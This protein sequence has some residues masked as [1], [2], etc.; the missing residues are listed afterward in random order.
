MAW[1]QNSHNCVPVKLKRS[2]FNKEQGGHCL[3]R[4][5]MFKR[6]QQNLAGDI[7]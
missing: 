3:G 1:Q 7:P 2:A 6:K 4:Q 5:I